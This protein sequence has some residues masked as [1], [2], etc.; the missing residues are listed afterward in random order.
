MHK[1]IMKLKTTTSL[2]NKNYKTN[3][4]KITFNI[5]LC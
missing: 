2:F 3:R 5:V 1:C 4:S